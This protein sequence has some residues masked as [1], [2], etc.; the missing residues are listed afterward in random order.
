M[1]CISTTQALSRLSQFKDKSSDMKETPLGLYLY[2]VLQ[3]ADILLYKGKRVPV[4]EDNLQNV[5]LSRR[6]ARSFN[7]RYCKKNE[8][9]FPIPKPILVSDKD[10]GAARVKS[11]RDPTKKMSKSDPDTK[12]CIYINDSPRDIHEK[13][14]KAVTDSTRNITYD[15]VNRPGVANLISIHSALTGLSPQEI[16]LDCKDMD[17]VKYKTHLAEIIIK[18]LTPIREHSEYLMKNRDILDSALKVGEDAARKIAVE[19]MNQVS[20]LVGLN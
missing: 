2:P 14:K 9:L 10:E 19:T 17:K 1:S 20:K 15:P 7:N 4:G 12:S 3:A 11:L 6:L 13:C 16:C 5:E 18:H 8:P